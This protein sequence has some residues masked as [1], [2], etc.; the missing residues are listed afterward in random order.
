LQYSSFLKVKTLKLLQDDKKSS[1]K[2]RFERIDRQYQECSYDRAAF[3]LKEN[4]KVSMSRCL[5]P[6]AEKS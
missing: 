2:K 3:P 4:Q 1:K 5:I 6:Q